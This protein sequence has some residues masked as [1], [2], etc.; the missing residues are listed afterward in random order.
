MNLAL[1]RGGAKNFFRTCAVG[2]ASCRSVKAGGE[3][4]TGDKVRLSRLPRP[5]GAH[6]HQSNR[7]GGVL[8]TL[9]LCDADESPTSPDGQ[10]KTQAHRPV[11]ARPSPS[12]GS[13]SPGHLE[14]LAD[15]AFLTARRL[16]PG[17]R[18]AHHRRR[19]RFLEDSS[20][21]PLITPAL[22]LRHLPCS[23]AS[24]A[25]SPS[26]PP[27]SSCPTAWLEFPG[28]RLHG[29][30]RTGRLRHP[31]LLELTGQ[32][33]SIC[34]SPTPAPTTWP[35][36]WPTL[37]CPRV[38]APGRPG[39]FNSSC[40]RPT[41]GGRLL[42]QPLEPHMLLSD[43]NGRKFNLIDYLRQSGRSEST[44]GRPERSGSRPAWWRCG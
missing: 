4:G 16:L 34:R 1:T 27:T 40:W 15:F 44:T 43:E 31:G 33:S 21:A 14:Q 37:V 22:S 20:A 9:F 32:A 10:A 5:P 28:W 11:F 38:A 29:R 41:T 3:R 18:P 6:D 30:L 2:N 8:Q 19:R 23:N 26:T 12:A 17:H 24:R 25:S 7:A 13:P 39:F 36:T 35:S 42:R